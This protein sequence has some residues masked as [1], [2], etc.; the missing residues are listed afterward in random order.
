MSEDTYKIDGSKMLHHPDRLIK[1]LN[2]GGELEKQLK[3]YPVYI[4]ISPV[5]GCNHRCTFCAVD[6][7]GYVSAN[8]LETSRLKDRLTEMGQKGVRSVMYA[9]E[10][11]PLLHK[12]L[13]EIIAHTKN[14]AGI[15][16]AITTNAT[17]LTDRFARIAL[18]YT[19]WIKASINAGSPEKYAA[20]HKTKPEHFELVW[21]NMANA[22]RVREEL[23]LPHD[24]PTLGAQMVLL[25]DNADTVIDFVKRAK[26]SGLDYA[27]VKPYSQHKR[28]YTKIYE[29]LKYDDYMNMADELEKL[30]DSN[31]HVV[32]R[33]S[34]MENLHKSHSNNYTVCPSTPFMW[35]YLRANG[36]L[37]GCSAYWLDDRFIYGNINEQSFSEAWESDKR[38]E[39]IRFVAEDLDITECRENCRMAR[40]NLDMVALKAAKDPIALIKQANSGKIPPHFNFI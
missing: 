20:I 29:G 23:G 38:R 7:L 40:V 35:A 36:D 5:G 31:F 10:G 30:D 37:Y 24:S 34:A 11:E 17:P 12:D 18:P 14:V 19:S 8:V 21:K 28:S 2:A 22:V 16:V 15:D 25:P 13:A 27:V 4:E 32:F 9:G 26:E 3:V 1:W 6:F 39:A 33:K